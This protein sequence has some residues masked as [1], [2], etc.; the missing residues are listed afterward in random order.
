MKK[1]P[2]P[3]LRQIS[4]CLFS[5][6][7]S[8]GS[9]INRSWLGRGFDLFFLKFF[10]SPDLLKAISE[11]SVLKPIEIILKI[12]RRNGDMSWLVSNSR[13]RNNV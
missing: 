2:Y 3:Q 8:L 7:H 5:I 1:I 13:N 10:R 12:A 6:D 4:Q 11:W 9:V